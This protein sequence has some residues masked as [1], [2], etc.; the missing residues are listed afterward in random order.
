[1]WETIHNPGIFFRD[2]YQCHLIEKVITSIKKKKMSQKLNS[3][4]LLWFEVWKLKKLILRIPSLKF[5]DYSLVKIF[6]PSCKYMFISKWMVP[7]SFFHVEHDPEVHM[8]DNFEVEEL[9]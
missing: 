2:R 9:S 4:E 7:W 3:T 6:M 5:S 1:M 8:A